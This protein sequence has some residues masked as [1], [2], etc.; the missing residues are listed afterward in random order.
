[1]SLGYVYLPT[2][3]IDYI[4]Q[5]IYYIKKNNCDWFLRNAV[6]ISFPLL[7]ATRLEMMQCIFFCTCYLCLVFGVWS[8][9]KEDMVKI[10]SS[11]TYTFHSKLVL[12][13]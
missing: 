5:C 7:S 10:L 3:V 4:E 9:H 12:C 13:R 6:S 1:M 11:H 8:V 2:S